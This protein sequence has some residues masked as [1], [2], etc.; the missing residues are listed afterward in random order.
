[1]KKVLLLS[2][3]VSANF[4][5]STVLWAQEDVVMRQREWK[6][7]YSVPS[8]GGI[9]AVPLSF[10]QVTE[11]ATGRI[12]D[13]LSG[14]RVEIQGFFEGEAENSFR[15]HRDTSPICQHCSS[16]VTKNERESPRIFAPASVIQQLGSGLIR[17]RGVAKYRPIALTVEEPVL[18]IQA[19]TISIPSE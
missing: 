11:V 6:E 5:F 15:L 10:S 18:E 12:P 7:V 2:Y 13:R 19:E 3:L 4:A 14:K 1:M 16:C 17:V 9:Q 8:N